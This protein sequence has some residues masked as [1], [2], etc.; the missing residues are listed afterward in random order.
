LKR[1]FITG[2]SGFV[3]ANL[4]RALLDGDDEVHLLLREESDPWRLEGVLERVTVHRGE[5]G[6]LDA[7]RSALR[8][9]RPDWIFHLAVHG[10]YPTQNDSAQ[11]ARTNV[12]GTANLL[13]AACEIG[14][15]SFVNTGSSSE[16][17]LKDHPPS[18]DELV[19]PNSVYAVTKVAATTLC[20]NAARETGRSITTLRLYSV[21]GPYE[22]PSRLIPAMI[23]Y[24]MQGTLPPLA[25]PSIAR[26]FVYTADVVDAYL[27]AARRTTGEAGAIYNVG[28]GVQTTLGD[29]VEVAREQFEMTAQPQWNTMDARSWD[30]TTWVASIDKIRR[31]LGWQPST[32]F[33]SGFRQT[34]QW[35]AAR[36]AKSR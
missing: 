24:G 27:R 17:G 2:G 29:V 23:A 16:Y 9:S 31:E 13:N 26:D 21:Y 5:V 35:Y 18:E 8:A 1:I 14:F 7:V 30:T 3:G 33:R 19:E 25:A 34:A 4:V 6:D 36:K 10:A 12:A 15:E 11:I 22:E 32:D 28:T 20:R